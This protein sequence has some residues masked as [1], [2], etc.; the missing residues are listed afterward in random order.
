MQFLSVIE[1]TTIG[2]RY[3]ALHH[4]VT[5]LIHREFAN[6]NIN[7]DNALQIFPIMGKYSISVLQRRKIKKILFSIVIV[8]YCIAVLI[9]DHNIISF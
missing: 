1:E 5:T 2:V 4:R 3:I 6:Y 9:S 7:L 8:D